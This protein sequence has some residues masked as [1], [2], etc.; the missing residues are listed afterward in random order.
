MDVK[1][2][3]HLI[4]NCPEKGVTEKGDDG[5]YPST[6]KASVDSRS[7]GVQGESNR[8]TEVVTCDETPRIDVVVTGMDSE[9]GGNKDMVE[10][11]VSDEKQSKFPEKERKGSTI[12]N[13][14][15]VV[16]ERREIDCEDLEMETETESFKMPHKRK[17]SDKSQNKKALKK[18]DLNFSDDN[19][20]ESESE[21]S[22][23]SV[24]LSQNEFSARSYN[25]E[26]VKVFLKLTKNKRGVCVVYK[27]TSLI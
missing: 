9:K 24:V 10:T 11:A 25:A 4:R 18:L 6:S 13:V 17:M 23:S 1:K 15:Q 12:G 5:S 26:E 3:G 8:E 2:I 20:T 27:S 14:A 16:Q 22:D 19:E 7:A 21:F